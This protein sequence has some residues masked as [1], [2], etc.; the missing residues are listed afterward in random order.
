MP[1][2]NLLID[3]FKSDVVSCFFFFFFF[4][5]FLSVG[6]FGFNNDVVTSNDDKL[7]LTAIS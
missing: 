7:R 6:C 3:Y 4:F 2:G 5:F 1:F